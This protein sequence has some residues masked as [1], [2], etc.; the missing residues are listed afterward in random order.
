VSRGIRISRVQ[1]TGERFDKFHDRFAQAFL[2]L[3]GSSMPR[4]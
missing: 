3:P 2:T 4:D 1:G